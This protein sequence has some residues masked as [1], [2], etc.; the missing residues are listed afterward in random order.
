MDLRPRLASGSR[1]AGKHV[2]LVTVITPTFNRAHTL[3]RVYRS[4][5]AQTLRDFEWVIVDDGSEDDTEELVESWV[6]QGAL[7]I[8]SLRQSNLGQYAAV[9]L[10]V[11]HARGNFT[12]LIDSDDWFEASALE[13]LLRHWNTIPPAERAG[14]SGVVGLCAFDDGRIVGD[15]FPSDPLDCDP[16]E[17][18]YLYQVQGDKHSMLRTEALREFPFPSDGSYVSP[19]LVWNRMALRYRERHFNEVVKVVEYQPGGLTDRGLELQ[20]RSPLPIRQFFLE[21][22]RLPHPIPRRRRLRSHANYVRFSLHAGIGLRGGM[23][24]APSKAAWLMLLPLG[25]ALYVRDR[26]RLR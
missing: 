9:N 3:S 1:I 12:T 14:F 21:E 13:T 18:A 25:F 4:L 15:E 8:R 24:E 19:Q 17:L 23:S 5:C 20:V 22:L 7:E 26:W 10:G 6:Q 16:A 11:Q 2:P